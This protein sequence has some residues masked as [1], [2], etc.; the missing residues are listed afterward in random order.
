MSDISSSWLGP[1]ILRLACL[2]I[3]AP[4]VCAQHT[5]AKNSVDDCGDPIPDTQDAFC[6]SILRGLANTL[7]PYGTENPRILREQ[8]ATHSGCAMCPCGVDPVV[9]ESDAEQLERIREFLSVSPEKRL[10]SATKAGDL[11]F[12]AAPKFMGLYVPCYGDRANRA[13]LHVMPQTFN[14]EVSDEHAELNRRVFL[15][16]RQYNHLLVN[17]LVCSKE[18]P[19]PEASLQRL[20]IE[21]T[22]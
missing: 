17:W 10:A 1:M 6:A 8:Y 7:D 12:L 19:L 5:G 2:I 20:G 18:I 15:Y 13:V 16:A 3:C 9:P 11:R 4:V 21:C 14:V 22:K